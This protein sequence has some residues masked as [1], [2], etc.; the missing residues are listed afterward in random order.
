VIGE[1]GSGGAI[2]IATGNRVYMLEHSIYSVISPEGAASILWR[3]STRAKEAAQNMK[4]T[5]EDLK[6]FGI[7][8]AIIPEPL[9][10]AHRDPAR[11]IGATGDVIAGAL[12]DLTGRDDLRGERR[13]KFLEMGRN[14]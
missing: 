4:I 9:G 6:Q 2:A 7:I 14:L 8:D 11:I 13:K 5:A 10:G 12:K 3:D 1:G